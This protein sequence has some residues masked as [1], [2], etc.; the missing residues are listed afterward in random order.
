MKRLLL[1]LPAVLLLTAI[2][3]AMVASGEP[4]EG[5]IV[6]GADGQSVMNPEASATLND[7]I[8]NVAPRFIME[9]ADVNHQYEFTPAPAEL[10][11]LI[12]QAADR[13]LIESADT[14]RLYLFKPAPEA[15]LDLIGQVADRFVM[16]S[17]DANRLYRLDYPAE[18]FNDY[19]YL[20]VII[21]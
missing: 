19:V 2:G 17:A 10:L 1:T 18:L 5:I 13:F 3:M 21:R 4:A 11:A 20:P 7:Q 6:E 8:A 16:E 12:S 14:N 9:A 15:L